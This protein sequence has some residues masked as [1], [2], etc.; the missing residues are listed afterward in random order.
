MHD[1]I[2]KKYLTNTQWKK[3]KETTSMSPVQI[4]PT[5]ISQ[6]IILTPHFSDQNDYYIYCYPQLNGEMDPDLNYLAYLAFHN[7]IQLYSEK[8]NT[9][10]VIDSVELAKVNKVYC[11]VMSSEFVIFPIIKIETPLDIKEEAPNIIISIRES[12]TTS[13]FYIINSTIPCYYW[14]GAYLQSTPPPS[15][16]E[17]KRKRKQFMRLYAEGKI[18]DLT[19]SEDY[20]LYCYSESVNKSPMR[21]S[22]AESSVGFKTLNSII[23]HELLCRLYENHTMEPDSILFVFYY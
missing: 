10:I 3:K 6:N 19:P 23:E 14:C 9:H 7:E 18:E 22:I 12:S 21:K 2:I 11:L 13:V 20:N 8:I 15:V 4:Y 5:V 1:T 16:T 17:L